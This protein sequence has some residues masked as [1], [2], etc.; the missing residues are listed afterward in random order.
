MPAMMIL[1]FDNEMVSHRYFTAGFEIGEVTC[2]Y[3]SISKKPAASI[4]AEV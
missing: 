2:P 4:S 3:Q 1:Y